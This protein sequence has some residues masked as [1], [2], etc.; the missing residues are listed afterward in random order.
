[1]GAASDVTGRWFS[2][3]EGMG[4]QWAG[5]LA[6]PIALAADQ[7]SSYALVKWTCGH[8]HP[9]VLHL[10]SLGA[11]VAIAAGAFAAWRGLAEAPPDATFEGGRPF[12]RGRFMAVL[13]LT[14]CALFAILVIAMAV[15]TWMID[16]CR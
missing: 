6:G 15:P 3:P 7:L 14:T 5:V 13:G 8:Q 11:L 1:M 2:S 10:I 9:I 4:A 12:D 16:A